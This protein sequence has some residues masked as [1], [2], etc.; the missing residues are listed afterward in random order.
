MMTRFKRSRR[1]YW[2]SQLVLNVL[3]TYRFLKFLG[4]TLL[5]EFGSAL[6][7]SIL[8]HYTVHNYTVYFPDSSV[9]LNHHVCTIH[10]IQIGV[11]LH[12]YY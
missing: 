9:Y 5:C 6:C 8:I 7:S 3:K 1:V 11:F 2:L 10:L 12:P 4:E